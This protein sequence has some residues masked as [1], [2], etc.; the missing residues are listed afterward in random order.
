MSPEALSQKADFEVQKNRGFWVE[1]ERRDSSPSANAFITY[2]NNSVVVVKG[3]KVPIGTTGIVF[4]MRP[5]GYDHNYADDA[6]PEYRLGIKDSSG[7]VYWTTTKNVELVD[8]H[9]RD[10]YC[11]ANLQRFIPEK[12]L[13]GGVASAEVGKDW[14]NKA[15][16]KWYLWVQDRKDDLITGLVFF[17]DFK[18][19]Q[20]IPVSGVACYFHDKYGEYEEV[21]V[22][23]AVIPRR[24]NE[25][26]QC[27]VRF[28]TERIVTDIE[29]LPL[30]KYFE[31]I[32]K[33]Q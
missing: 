1:T 6:E 22:H 26:K 14:L 19:I 23:V 28:E 13:H 3:R 4:W 20:V 25:L 33:R 15:S 27:T 5:S 2:Y 12:R 8:P 21:D 29:A 9:S 16:V 17:K 30:W 24:S 32:E 31:E 18:E 7:N 11:K 10:K